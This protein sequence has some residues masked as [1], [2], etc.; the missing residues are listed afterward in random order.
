M[1]DYTM[2]KSETMTHSLIPLRCIFNYS[3]HTK[4]QNPV[5]TLPRSIF[6]RGSKQSNIEKVYLLQI[7]NGIDKPALRTIFKNGTKVPF[8]G[9]I[10]LRIGIG[11]D[12]TFMVQEKQRRWLKASL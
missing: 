1:I 6:K 9:I 5:K 2:I 8:L 3:L 12:K 10:L 11:K 4:L 7:H